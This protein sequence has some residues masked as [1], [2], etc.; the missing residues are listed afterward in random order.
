MGGL[1]AVFPLAMI[2]STRLLGLFMVLPVIML[3]EGK[4]EGATPFLL[5]LVLGGYGLTQAAMQIPFGLL[6]DRFGRKPIVLLGLILFIIGSVLAGLT[7]NIYVIII[8][9]IL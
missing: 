2:F 3:Y 9:R 8:G 1:T 6:S 4:L 5:G 7:D